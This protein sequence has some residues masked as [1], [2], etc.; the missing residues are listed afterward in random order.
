MR[1]TDALQTYRHSSKSVSQASDY[2]VETDAIVTKSQAIANAG[3]NMLERLPSLIRSALYALRGGSL[4]RPLA[5]ALALV[6]T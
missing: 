5:I 1:G 3:P 2:E 4:I 6:Q